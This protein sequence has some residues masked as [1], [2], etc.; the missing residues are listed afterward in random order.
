MGSIANRRMR[1]ASFDNWRI[2]RDC[3]I[4]A[5][6][7]YLSIFMPWS[8][9]FD[10]PSHRLIDFCF[11]SSIY[12]NLLA[13]LAL[14][15]LIGTLLNFITPLGAFLQLPFPAI[16][17]FGCLSSPYCPIILF[18]AM[19][20][21]PV[22][23]FSALLVIRSIFKPKF[24]G[25][26]TPPRNVK[27]RLLT[28]CIVPEHPKIPCAGTLQEAAKRDYRKWMPIFGIALLYISIIVLL[29]PKI[30]SLRLSPYDESSFILYLYAISVASCASIGSFL[31]ITTLW[32]A[33]FRIEDKII[34]PSAGDKIIASSAGA[35]LIISSFIGIV[36]SLSYV[37]LFSLILHYFS[38]L[39][40]LNLIAAFL[41]LF[42]L[43]G[44]A[45]SRKRRYWLFSIAGAISVICASILSLF[46]ENLYGILTFVLG[47]IALF[48]IVLSRKY[49][50][51]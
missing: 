2:N 43:I 34:A 35:L 28:F 6:I 16:M 17:T 29:L 38:Y 36:D 39:L 13:V 45:L 27:E 14:L 32:M 46:A 9:V 33:A 26:S 11:S 3:V 31:I 1:L 37:G 12:S 4:F 23:L 15:C 51:D 21:I 24:I 8:F 25:N 48:L 5:L 22:N 42:G 7:G 18:L 19:I 47:A 44:G 49:F 50:R 41:F 10:A 20:G 40:M 30:F